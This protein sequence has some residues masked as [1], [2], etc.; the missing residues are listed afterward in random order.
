MFFGCLEWF[1]GVSYLER[2]VLDPM[3]K[4]TI[5]DKIGNSTFMCVLT[6]ALVRILKVLARKIFLLMEIFEIP[7]KK[8]FCHVP[9]KK[10]WRDRASRASANEGP[11]YIT[12]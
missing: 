11:A 4:N 9:L 1:F 5:F 6:R 10:Y 12:Y 7:P 3:L 8:F 2:L